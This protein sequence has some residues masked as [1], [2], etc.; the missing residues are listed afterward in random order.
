MILFFYILYIFCD[1]SQEKQMFIV[2]KYEIIALRA[3][4]N[5]AITKCCL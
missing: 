2:L 1:K 4:V 3:C 5:F